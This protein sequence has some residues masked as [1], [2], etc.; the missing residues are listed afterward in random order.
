MDKVRR[1]T[2]EITLEKKFA[3]TIIII[4]I[5]I[6]INCLLDLYYRRGGEDF[7]LRKCD[8]GIAFKAI[9]YPEKFHG[10]I[11]VSNMDSIFQV[12]KKTTFL[13]RIC[14]T[15]TIQRVCS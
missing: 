7:S 12:V 10:S 6:I 1:G 9:K 4:I 2:V 13:P 14:I 8:R 15:V 5:I 3:I 11:S